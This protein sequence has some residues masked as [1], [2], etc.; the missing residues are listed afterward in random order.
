MKINIKFFLWC[1]IIL[2][3]VFNSNNSLAVTANKNKRSLLYSQTQPLL[4]L[5]KQHDFSV[6]TGK[7]PLGLLIEMSKQ[8]DIEQHTWIKSLDRF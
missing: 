5:I 1:I 4:F 3:L 6:L 8:F 7:K 2:L